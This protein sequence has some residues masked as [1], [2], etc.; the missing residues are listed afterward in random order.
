MKKKVRLAIKILV[1]RGQQKLLK[2]WMRYVESL[3]YEK[4]VVHICEIEVKRH[5]SDEEDVR[6]YEYIITF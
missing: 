4:E 6:S 3:K 2:G 1:A 5:L